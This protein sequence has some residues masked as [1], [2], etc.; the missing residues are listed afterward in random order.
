MNDCSPKR[1]CIWGDNEGIAYTPGAACL[2]GETFNEVLCDCVS[3]CESGFFC[4]GSPGDECCNSGETCYQPDRDNPARSC[5]NGN[6]IDIYENVFQTGANTQVTRRSV[7]GPAIST[8]VSPCG[9]NGINA[10][11]C[12]GQ[13]IGCNLPNARP[14]WVISNYKS[15]SS[16][17]CAQQ[18]GTNT[19]FS[20]DD[21]TCANAPQP[22]FGPP[23]LVSS[24]IV[25]S[26][27]CTN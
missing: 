21:G 22:G 14:W 18:N 24:T 10:R 1:K 15:S 23:V 5:C 16:G 9:F 26:V 13:S 8:T 4:P 11:D 25:E 12:T 3:V 6:V 27:C 17:G 7:G 19:G 2:P 20:Y